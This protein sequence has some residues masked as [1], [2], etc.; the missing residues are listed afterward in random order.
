MTVF[1][2]PRRRA[3]VKLTPWEGVM[4]T[5]DNVRSDIDRSNIDAAIARALA[6]KRIVGTVVLIARNGELVY[7]RAAGLADREAGREMRVDALFRLASITK[8]IVCATTM[9]LGERQ[10]LSLD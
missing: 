6:E 3:S 1:H 5:L 8:A 2:N 4:T 7:Q 9:A 10:V